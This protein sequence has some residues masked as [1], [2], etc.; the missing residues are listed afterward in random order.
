MKTMNL[1]FRI[2][3]FVLLAFLFFVSNPAIT[4]PLR[5][6]PTTITQ[7]DGQIIKCF[8]TGDEFYHWLH[9]EN[10]YTIIRNEADSWYYFAIVENDSLVPSEYKVG[11]VNPLKT[12]L[13]PG[14]RLSP[15]KILLQRSIMNVGKK[16]TQAVAGKNV[17]TLNNIVVFV[18]FADDPEFGDSISVYEKMFNDSTEGSCS[19]YAYFKEV[20]YNRM[21]VKTHF[22]PS[23]ANGM[24]VSY[25]DSKMRSYYQPKTS[26]NPY[27]YTT[28]ENKYGRLAELN[29]RA[30]KSIQNEI[31]QELNLD[32]DG[33]G[34]IDN[35]CFILKGD[36]DS[37]FGAVL[38][39]RSYPYNSWADIKYPYVILNGKKINNCVLQIQRSMKET[40]YALEHEMFHTMG[41]TDLYHYSFDMFFPL[42]IW[43]LMQ[44]GSTTPPSMSAYMKFRYGGWI[45]SIPTIAKSG[46]YCLAPLSSST[47]NC[48]KI[49]SPNS[50]NFY[51]VLEYRK[52][53]GAFESILPGD[54]LLV[55]R[56]NKSSNGL[57]NTNATT[58]TDELYVYRPGGKT[59]SN[60]IISSAFLN[61]QIGR[62]L[63]NDNTPTSCFLPGDKPGGIDISE[64]Q[65]EGDS[66]SFYVRFEKTPKANFEVSTR[67]SDNGKVKFFD[68]SSQSPDSYLWD[69]GDGQKSD[70]RDPIHYYTQNDT[71]DV[72]LIVKNQLGA[73]TLMKKGLIIIDR[74]Q[75]P[76]NEQIETIC[77]SGQ[78]NLKANYS[79]DGNIVWYND[80]FVGEI[81]ANEDDNFTIDL[82]STKTFYSAA[83]ISKDSSYFLGAK[84]T[85]IGPTLFYRMM[86]DSNHDIY[87]DCYSDI[88]LK[89]VKVYSA[90]DKERRIQIKNQK[91]EILFDSLIYIPKGEHRLSMNVAIDAGKDYQLLTTSVLSGPGI[92]ISPDLYFNSNGAEYPYEIPGVI[93]I[94]SSFYGS[95]VYGYFYDWEV[96]QANS[97]SPRAPV[98]VEVI[99]AKINPRPL[100]KL[101]EGS[102]VELTS[103]PATSYLWSP[104]GETTQ[105]IIAEDSDDYSVSTLIGDCQNT[106]LPVKISYKKANPE[107]PV[108]Y[109]I[110][111]TSVKFSATVVKGFHYLF[112]YGDSKTR[113]YDPSPTAAKDTFVYTLSNKYPNA[114]EYNFWQKVTGECR[115][116]S[117]LQVI[118]ILG[119]NVENA[120]ILN[121]LEIFP[122]PTS[123]TIQFTPPISTLGQGIVVVYDYTGRQVL[124]KTLSYLNRE[125]P[126]SLDLG[127][128]VEGIY[129]IR[130]GV[131]NERYSGRVLLIN[132]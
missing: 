105:S 63:I 119:T 45:D 91:G 89:S 92:L 20:S 5:N 22:F 62:G 82:D 7:P 79:G 64:I 3:S 104:G 78:I 19:M 96:K 34:Y 122:N 94:T 84:D 68:N 67:Y 95:K 131:G 52:R 112:E 38:W 27:G 74:P 57:G 109:T 12:N 106:S 59:K 117:F 8:V 10:D 35:V 11:K 58:L 49:N 69:F 114:G 28:F 15:E 25:T 16:S 71:F 120:S 115:T 36:I 13:E 100:V 98:T 32:Y 61:K 46:S 93:S 9:D 21:F 23:A 127:E 51:F 50:A 6:Y 124:T 129:L 17:G 26:E 76:I 108:T 37:E 4:A 118:T 30:S 99:K 101:C 116:D 14:A 2:Q 60:G 132:K 65:K 113:Q 83:E 81:V 18:R 97:S 31:S 29:Y 85:A 53:T 41:A 111:G 44:T 90:S 66:I 88:F 1:A 55:Y 24:V 128:L 47:K 110:T 102:S 54:G 42:G 87:F 73:D 130:L 48:Y 86:D 72:C 56:V 33:N 40:P 39:P 80:P 77:N 43:D 70:E 103:S 75:T 125:E 123:G 121:N 126:V 107:I